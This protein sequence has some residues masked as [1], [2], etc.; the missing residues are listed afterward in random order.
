MGLDAAFSDNPQD[1]GNIPEYDTFMNEL[2]ELYAKIFQIMTPGKYCAV[3]MQNTLKQN[4]EFYPAAWEFALKMRNFGWQICQEY[5]WC[6]R[7]KKLGIW[8]YPNTYIL[9]NLWLQAE[10]S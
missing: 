1:F 6:Q 2:L 4:Q 3:I 9:C 8:G 5:I 10:L 7:D